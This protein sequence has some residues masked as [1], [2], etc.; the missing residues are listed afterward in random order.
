M[1]VLTKQ[2]YGKIS[3]VTKHPLIYQAAKTSHHPL[4]AYYSFSTTLGFF[5]SS[6]PAFQPKHEVAICILQEC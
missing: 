2:P 5:V 4:K 3:L 6:P 1:R